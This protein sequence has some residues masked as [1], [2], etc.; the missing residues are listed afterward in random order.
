MLDLLLLPLLAPAVLTTVE[1]AVP[2]VKFPEIDNALVMVELEEKSLF[3][4]L[5]DVDA[6]T[7]P[8]YV[9]ST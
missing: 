8:E 4:M 9:N 2:E 5:E 7:S 1:I 6:R 3:V